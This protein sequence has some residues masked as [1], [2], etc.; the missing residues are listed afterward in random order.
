MSATNGLDSSLFQSSTVR[1][2][3]A[4]ESLE[5]KNATLFQRQKVYGFVPPSTYRHQAKISGS[6]LVSDF[7][8]QPL[9]SLC[10][11]GSLAEKNNHRGTENTEVAQRRIQ[12]KT[13]SKNYYLRMRR[14]A[15]VLVHRIR[16]R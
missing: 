5:S 12:L 7:S 11:C 3:A 1:F 2:R 14:D 13:P 8:V 9:C 6:V 16:L 15:M 4:M 10:L